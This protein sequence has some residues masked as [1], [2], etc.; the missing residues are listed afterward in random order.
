MPSSLTRVLTSSLG[1]LRGDSLARSREEAC[2]AAGL[3][4]PDALAFA[5]A[6][7]EAARALRERRD[8]SP[9]SRPAQVACYLAT[10]ALETVRSRGPAPDTGADVATEE[11]AAELIARG[12]VPW[13]LTDRVADR[14]AMEALAEV[15][16]RLHP[17]RR[18]LRRFGWSR[19][20][21]RWRAFV[22][23][24]PLAVAVALLVGFIYLKVR[25]KNLLAGRP[26]RTSSASK[27]FDAKGH[28]WHGTQLPVFFVTNIDPEPWIEYDLGQ[29]TSLRRVVADNRPDGAR[30]RAV[31]LVIELSDDQRQWHELGRMTQDF[32][33]WDARFPV[34]TGRYLRL[35]VPRPTIL[36]LESVEAYER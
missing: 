35:R 16:R 21:A 9:S 2:R 7:G 13:T 36:H 1:W 3:E 22:F 12:A 6:L 11:R 19:A 20:L 30:E 4:D 17:F 33:S 15:D 26:F 5:L 23:A 18:V 27:D 34:V 24:V 32:Y 14:T 8:P 31:P 28:T 25:P 10:S 29:P